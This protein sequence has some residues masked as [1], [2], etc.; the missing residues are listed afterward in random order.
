MHGVFLQHAAGVTHSYYNR[1]LAGYY[2][3]NM[4]SITIPAFALY[5]LLGA[6]R[7]KSLNYALSAAITFT[8]IVS[9]MHL[10]SRLLVHWLWHI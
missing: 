5:F 4:F 2:D 1:T 9:F 3:T 6:S 7:K 10:V 8:V